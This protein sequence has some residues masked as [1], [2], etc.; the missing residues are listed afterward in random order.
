MQGVHW[1]NSLSKF[2]GNTKGNERK[3]C[4][5]IFSIKISKLEIV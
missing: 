5:R 3:D 1:D 4:V 2:Q